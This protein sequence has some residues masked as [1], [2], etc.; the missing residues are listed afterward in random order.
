[1]PKR[2]LSPGRRLL[3][4]LMSG[5]G[6]R[7]AYEISRHTNDGRLLTDARPELDGLIVEEQ[8][9]GRQSKRP[10]RRVSLTLRGLAAAQA[11]QPG[12]EPRRLATPILKQWFDELVREHDGW[13]Y[14]LAR[15][16][17]EGR[18]YAAIKKDLGK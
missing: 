16:A 13:A 5:G 11:V 2:P 4:F 14:A 6:S 8:S 1:M 17:E 12:W 3:L 7:T 18:E 15:G 10:C 9:R